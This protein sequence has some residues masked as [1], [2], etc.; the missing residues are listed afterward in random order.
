MVHAIQIEGGEM[1]TLKFMAWMACLVWMRPG[2]AQDQSCLAVRDALTTFLVENNY[3][4][5]RAF[6][7]PLEPECPPVSDADRILDRLYSSSLLQLELSLQETGVNLSDTSLQRLVW[8]QARWELMEYRQ[9]EGVIGQVALSAPNER[10]YVP[11]IQI[12]GIVL[13]LSLSVFFIQ[14]RRSLLQSSEVLSES[15]EVWFPDVLDLK[16]ALKTARTTK[17]FNEALFD[18]KYLEFNERLMLSKKEEWLE[19]SRRE[20]ELIFMLIEQWSNS[21]ICK[22]LHVSEN[23]LYRL[24]SQLRA[25]LDLA[26]DDQLIPALRKWAADEST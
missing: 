4:A 2:L 26:S 10:S 11:Y 13:L 25:S 5:F 12:T 24:R 7:L 8:E 1:K 14:K 9:A 20:R 22:R 19:K 6:S 18:L 3:E 23:H 16:K 21:D 17:E 15:D